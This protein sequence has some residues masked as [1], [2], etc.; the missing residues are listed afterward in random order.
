MV[1][2]SRNT[3]FNKNNIMNCKLLVLSLGLASAA[4]AALFVNPSVALY[5]PAGVVVLGPVV[6]SL[7]SPVVDD[8]GN[9]AAT[10]TSTVHTGGSNPLGGLTFTYTLSNDLLPPTN[11]D[12]LYAFSVLWNPSYIPAVVDIDTA[13]PGIGVVPF[14]FAATGTG[15]VFAFN[16]VALPVGSSSVT[17]A[18]GTAA[19]AWTMGDAGIINGSTE[20][21]RALV[22]VPE[23]STYALLAG[24]GLVG[25]AAYRRIRS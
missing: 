21:S 19:P 13:P 25:F 1:R 3:G 10:L 7:T 22:P 11:A 2:M 24:L 15:M 16:F 23:P 6:A 4:N 8:L 12:A 20:D 9:F 18:V 17:I 14:A 5:P